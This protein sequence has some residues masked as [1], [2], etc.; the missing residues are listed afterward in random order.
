MCLPGEDDLY[1]VLP[2]R[3]PRSSQACRQSFQLDS[4]PPKKYHNN[5]EPKPHLHKFIII[6]KCN[7]Q[8]NPANKKKKK[9]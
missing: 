5:Q 3:A 6:I 4:G 7:S 2:T 8:L 1:P 9:K